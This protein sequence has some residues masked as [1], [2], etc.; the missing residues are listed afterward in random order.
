V[1]RWRWVALNVAYAVHDRQLAEHGG[2]SGIRDAGALEAALARPKNLAAYKNAD[3]AELAAC[4]AFSLARN[5][6]FADGNKRTA[7]VLARVFLAENGRRITFEP[8][9]AVRLMEGLA[10]GSVTEADAATW[11]RTRLSA[12]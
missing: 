7:W 11:F 10:S 3:A 1:K 9:D 2:L 8:I 5:H 6:P 4:Y 12:R